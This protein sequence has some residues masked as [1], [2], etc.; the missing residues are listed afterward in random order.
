MKASRHGGRG[1]LRRPAA[2]RARIIASLPRLDARRP[3]GRH[4]RPPAHGSAGAGCLAS[5]ARVDGGS[6]SSTPSSACPACCPSTATRSSGCCASRPTC[7]WASTRP[8]ST[9]AWSASCARPAR[10]PCISS[11]PR[12]GPSATSAST[13]SASRSRTCW[14]CSLRGRDLPQGERAG[15]PTWATRWRRPS[16]M[17]PDAAARAAGHRGRRARAGH[18][19]GQPGLGDPP[20][21]ATLPAGGAGARCG[22]IRRCNASCPWSTSSRRGI[23]GAVLAQ[24][25]VPGLRCV[26]AE[27]IADAASRQSGGQ[28]AAQPGGAY[29]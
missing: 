28:G 4:R 3:G 6:A 20:D 7:S 5:H 18:P 21:G 11:G 25:P 9:S 23:R 2:G 29:P 15:L 16:R 17:K 19:A 8:T 1:A 27:D 12:S 26:M 22:A 10:P 14:C 13:R 24:Y